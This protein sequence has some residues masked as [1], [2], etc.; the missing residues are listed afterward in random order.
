METFLKVMKIQLNPWK[1][2]SNEI[3]NTSH[4]NEKSTSLHFDRILLNNEIESWCNQQW[5]NFQ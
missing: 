5:G 1:A 4:A 2:D 3:N